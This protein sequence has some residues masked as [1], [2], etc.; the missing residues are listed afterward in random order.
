MQKYKKI[1]IKCLKRKCWSWIMQTKY[2]ISYKI[3]IRSSG[4]KIFRRIIKNFKEIWDCSFSSRSHSWNM[5]K[6]V[7]QKMNKLKYSQ[8]KT[9]KT[10]KNCLEATFHQLIVKKI[11]NIEHIV[12]K[13]LF[14]LYLIILYMLCIKFIKI[15]RA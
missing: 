13:K 14:I 15:I 10:T 11:Y 3:K 2:S 7:R 9:K 1:W 4:L 6:K 5:N 8:R 12:Y